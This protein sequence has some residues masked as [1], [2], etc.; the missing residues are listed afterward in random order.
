MIGAI[1]IAYTSHAA[2]KADLN[3]EFPRFLRARSN[4]NADEIADC[5]PALGSKGDIA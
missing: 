2:S 3:T 4:Q 1:P 5:H